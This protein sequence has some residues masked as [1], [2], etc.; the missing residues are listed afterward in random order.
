L[1]K[2]ELLLVMPNKGRLYEPTLQTLSLAEI[3]IRHTERKYLCETSLPDLKILLARAADIPTYVYHGAADLGITGLD[4]VN[5]SR[6]ELYELLDLK[7][8]PCRLVLAVPTPSKVKAVEDIKKGFR[9]ATEYPN[10]TRGFFEQEGIQV[11]IITIHGAAEITPALGLA[12]GITDL[13]ATGST[14]KANDLREVVTILKSSTRLFSN[15][16][17]FRT[18]NNLIQSFVDR[19]KRGQ[20][21]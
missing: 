9:I 13:V 7:Y 10:L 14:L 1:G 6:A 19:M 20:S 18:K 15:K 16:I 5:E 11:D 12:D 21:R 3:E 2:N 4:M 8:V 17:A